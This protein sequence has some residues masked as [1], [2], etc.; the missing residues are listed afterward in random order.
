[1]ATAPHANA[2]QQ[3]LEYLADTEAQTFFAKAN[4]EYPVVSGAELAPAVAG[5]GTFKDDSTNVSTYGIN[6]A[7]AVQLMD[8]VGWA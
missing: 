2:A 6:Q 8:R 7:A 3:F 5:F 4:N 1:V